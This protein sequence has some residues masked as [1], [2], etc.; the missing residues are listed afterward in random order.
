ML[1]L[2]SRVGGWGSEG[3]GRSDLTST[4][5]VGYVRGGTLKFSVWS[6][7]VPWLHV[8]SARKHWSV[9]LFAEHFLCSGMA[10]VWLLCVILEAGSILS[11]PLLNGP[12]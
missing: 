12:H 4:E 1:R 10:V 9:A 2:L 5:R 3:G 11:S 8:R 6:G 7:V